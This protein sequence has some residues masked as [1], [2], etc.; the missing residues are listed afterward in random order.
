MIKH[1]VF[2]SGVKKKFGK[3][4]FIILTLFISTLLIGM[5]AFIKYHKGEGSESFANL[6][7]I[8][9]I[10]KDSWGAHDDLK[11]KKFEK[12]VV[13]FLSLLICVVALVKYHQGERSESFT[14]LFL[15]QS[16]VEDGW[17]THNDL[18]S[19]RIWKKSCFFI[20]RY[21]VV[22]L[23]KYHQSEGCQSFANL[24]LVQCIVK[25]RPG[26]T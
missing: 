7:L 13:V 23:I 6:F 4:V 9:S 24:F 22:T 17:G 1:I 25:D 14:H 21:L 15:V 11:S 10:V 19:E 18:K 20:T 16:I 26:C 3:K 5:V 12:K 2:F 8:Q